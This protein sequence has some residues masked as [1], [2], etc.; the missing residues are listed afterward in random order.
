M[1]INHPACLLPRR[2]ELA[3][4]ARHC[5]QGISM[6]D[7]IESIRETMQPLAGG[8]LTLELPSWQ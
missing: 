5:R 1:G 2:N 8:K 7:P 6:N 3:R 4:E